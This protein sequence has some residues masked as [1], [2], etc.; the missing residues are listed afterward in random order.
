MDKTYVKKHA[1]LL[2]NHTYKTVDLVMCWQTF[3]RKHIMNWIQKSRHRT[4]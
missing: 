1:N 3:A 2:C 4:R